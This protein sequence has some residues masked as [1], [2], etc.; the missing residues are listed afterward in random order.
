MFRASESRIGAPRRF[1]GM[2]VPNSGIVAPSIEPQ[3]AQPARPA[4]PVQSADPVSPAPADPAASQPVPQ[5]PLSAP[6]YDLQD[7]EEIWRDVFEEAEAIKPSMNAMRKAQLVA[8]NDREF[9]VIVDSPFI[10]ARLESEKQ[11]IADLMEK[12]TG[13]QRRMAV[14]LDSDEEQA[15]GKSVRE[16][17]AEASQLIGVEVKVKREE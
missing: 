11:M 13:V 17:A 3:T 15:A 8:M 12:R 1:S 9:K 5:E 10:R 14:R 2:G 7:L 16:L 4:E 6:G